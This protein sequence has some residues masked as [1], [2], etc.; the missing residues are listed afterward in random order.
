MFK[1]IMHIVILFS[2]C[3]CIMRKLFVFLM[4]CEI[5]VQPSVDCFMRKLVG[6]FVNGVLITVASTSSGSF[7]G[8]GSQPKM[9]DSNLGPPLPSAA[10][11]ASDELKDAAREYVGPTMPADLPPFKLPEE[12]GYWVRARELHSWDHSSDLDLHVS[13]LNSGKRVLEFRPKNFKVR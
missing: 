12:V 11:G 6:L 5:R 10:G 7:R 8:L 13:Y 2:T 1:N 3:T 9:A 4:I